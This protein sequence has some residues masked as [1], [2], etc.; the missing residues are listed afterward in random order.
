MMKKI[1]TKEL[2]IY[3]IFNTMIKKKYIF[4]S[5]NIIALS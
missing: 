3:F 1:G 2:R 5:R 4:K